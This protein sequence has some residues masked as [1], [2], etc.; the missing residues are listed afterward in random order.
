MTNIK[1]AKVSAL[2]SPLA[3]N[4]IYLIPG[5]NNTTTIHISNDSGTAVRSAPVDTTKGTDKIDS[6]FLPASILGQLEYKGSRDMTTALPAAATENLGW[7]Y[8]TAVPGNGYNLGDWAVSNGASW[9]KVDN[10]DSIVTV[11]GVGPVAGDV[12]VS[13]VANIVGGNNTTL[14]GSI[15]YQVD[16]DT[17]V[18]LAPNTSTTKMM[19]TQ[20]GNGINGNVPV[21]EAI[22]PSTTVAVQW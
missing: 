20:T 5:P 16:T 8:I 2:P 10:S 6:S 21:W 4:T 3:A 12:T 15:L 7:Y 14:K 19:L 11:N 18:L 22:T 13:K 17:T 1:I 9:D